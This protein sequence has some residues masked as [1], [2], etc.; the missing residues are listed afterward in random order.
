M[1]LGNAC[2]HNVNVNRS[3]YNEDLRISVRYETK[4]LFTRASKNAAKMQSY[5]GYDRNDEET[6]LDS[7]FYLHRPRN[8]RRTQRPCTRD[9]KVLW[10]Y[11]ITLHPFRVRV[12]NVEIE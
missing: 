4:I 11:T 1:T 2:T 3:L 6:Y 12:E 7:R 8:N 5:A 10:Y 9:N